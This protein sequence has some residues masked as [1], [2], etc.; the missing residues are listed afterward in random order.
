MDT[1][2]ALDNQVER[3]RAR[4]KIAARP[5]LKP[6]EPGPHILRQPA[7]PAFLVSSRSKHGH[8]R[9]MVMFNHDAAVMLA[10]KH[11]DDA[12]SVMA[13]LK[14]AHR[15]QRHA[16]FLR[17]GPL[18]RSINEASSFL[19]SHGDVWK[20]A[21]DGSE[22]RASDGAI[23]VLD[24]SQIAVPETCT[25]NL[26]TALI[27]ASQFARTFDAA[28]GDRPWINGREAREISYEE[29]QNSQ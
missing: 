19:R 23:G 21:K 4:Q 18:H 8:V 14:R 2:F 12:F 13:K 10:R 29:L 6:I 27:L 16:I 1:Q 25:A 26:C 3:H 15:W 9:S 22:R 11:K 28:F 7:T 17:G 24:R 5:I 20:T